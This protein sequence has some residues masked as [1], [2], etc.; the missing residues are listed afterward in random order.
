LTQQQLENTVDTSSHFNHND[1]GTL[2]HS[3][4]SNKWSIAPFSITVSNESLVTKELDI[5]SS[6]L[7]PQI[8]QQSIRNNNEARHVITQDNLRSIVTAI[9]YIE[10][11]NGFKIRDLYLLS[12]T[13]RIGKMKVNN[14]VYY[15]LQPFVNEC[16]DQILH[17]KINEMENF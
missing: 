17:G 15:H 10:R 12:S 14:D 1:D 9:S 7:S 2:Q 5:E 3:N 11:N 16:I 6:C 13:K 8:N 4:K